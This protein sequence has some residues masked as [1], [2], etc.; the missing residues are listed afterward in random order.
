VRLRVDYDERVISQAAAFLGDP[1]GIRAVLDA[2]G[3]LA[4]DSRPDGSFPYGSPDLRR[5]RVGR[6]RVL[7]EISEDATQSGISPAEAYRRHAGVPH[8]S[9]SPWP[10]G[11]ADYRTV[12][13]RSLNRASLAPLPA[14]L[15]DLEIGPCR[16]GGNR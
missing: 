16:A 2:N 9:A 1:P 13:R 5:L 10:R 3:K 11:L 6:Y 12:T 4:D 7:Y 15:S 14:D 8:I